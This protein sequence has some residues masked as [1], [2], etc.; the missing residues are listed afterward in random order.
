MKNASLLAAA[1]AISYWAAATP[2]MASENQSHDCAGVASPAERLTCYDTAFPPVVDPEARA[3]AEEKAMKNFGLSETELRERDPD[4]NRAADRSKIEATVT[5]VT[6]RSD[7][8]RVVTL[9]N[10]QVWALT[11]AT[12][13]GPLGAGDRVEIRTAALGTYMLLTPSGVPLRV[14]RIN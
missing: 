8:R 10:G 6:H 4:P 11:R 13:M 1:L 9:D 14:R 2:T 7:D 12:S 3:L 5:A